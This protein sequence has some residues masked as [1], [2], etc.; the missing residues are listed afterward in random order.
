M[1]RRIFVP[2]D[3]STSSE[4]ALPVASAI[5]QILGA[6]LLLAQVHE[7]VAAIHRSRCTPGELAVVDEGWDTERRRQEQEYLDARMHELA[8]RTG[9]SGASTILDGP[10]ANAL[11]DYAMEATIDL[12]V[13]G[14]R[15]RDGVAQPGL[16][17]V[18]D[19]FVRHSHL[20]VL[21]VPPY[22]PTR[23]DLWRQSAPCAGGRDV[24]M[25]GLW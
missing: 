1:Y 5:A 4:Q 13:L 16:G 20:L 22:Q 7:P 24:S 18:A 15:R 23:E 17:Q 2:L 25:A 12:V 9:L 19:A 8:Q 11:L 6:D 3:G 10:V 14:L 21:T